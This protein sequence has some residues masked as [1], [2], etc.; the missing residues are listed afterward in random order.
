MWDGP[1]SM[2]G[3]I[4]H[5]EN[6]S[7]LK[8]VLI[9]LFSVTIILLVDLLSCMLLCTKALTQRIEKYEI[10]AKFFIFSSSYLLRWQ[11]FRFRN[12]LFNKIQGQQQLLEDFY[13]GTIWLICLLLLL[14]TL[15]TVAQ[16]I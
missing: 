5:K 11:W 9:I 6:T 7:R 3:L 15:D 13:L 2:V 16:I 8:P 14:A 4:G 12:G 10:E 1:I